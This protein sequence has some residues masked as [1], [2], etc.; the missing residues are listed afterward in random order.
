[1]IPYRS[2][3]SP[4]KAQTWSSL[5]PTDSF[6]ARLADS[7]YV[8]VDD[9]RTTSRSTGS[10]GIILSRPL[11]SS[12]D[13]CAYHAAAVP[14]RLFRRRSRTEDAFRSEMEA[15]ALGIGLISTSLVWPKRG[16]S[17]SSA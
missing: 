6:Y 16:G 17:S 8:L 13:G 7:R 1:M 14:R 2:D 5:V 10:T 3:L 12:V 9:V 11:H 15:C 4:T